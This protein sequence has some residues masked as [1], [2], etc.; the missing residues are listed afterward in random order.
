MAVWGANDHSHRET[1][2]FKILAADG[3][4]KQRYLIFKLCI[5]WIY[6]YMEVR[7]VTGGPNCFFDRATSITYNINMIFFSSY[8]THIVLMVC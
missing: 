3:I 1:N 8:Y 7:S 6:E 4:L 2:E 5:I